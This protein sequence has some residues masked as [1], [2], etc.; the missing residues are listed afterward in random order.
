VLF[1]PLVDPSRVTRAVGTARHLRTAQSIADRTITVLRN[2]AHLLP[3]VVKPRSVLVTG[4]GDVTT[5]TLAKQISARGCAVTVLATVQSPTDTQIGT[6]VATAGQADL[7]VVLTDALGAN[8]SQQKLLQA[9]IATGRP[10]IAIAVQNPY[11]AGYVDAAQTWLATYG[12]TADSTEA[13][14]KVIFGEI[15]P[16]GKLPVDVP[17]GTDPS[18]VRYPFGAGLTW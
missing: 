17:S 6:A 9:L 13:V 12:Y 7:V 3:L 2:D 15:P 10:V 4:W 18:Q 14:T 11:D 8:P 16:V 1:R 5:A